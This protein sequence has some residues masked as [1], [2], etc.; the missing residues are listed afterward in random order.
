VA[1]N[2]VARAAAIAAARLACAFALLAARQAAPVSGGEKTRQAAEG[3][4]ELFDGKDLAGW[5]VHSGTARFRVENEVVIGESVAKS[6]NSFLCSDESF[7]DFELTLEYEVDAAL[8]S[9]VQ[10]RSEF[11]PQARTLEID[12]RSIP[13]PAD[14]VHGYQVEIDMDP[15]RNRWWSGGL[16]D[17]ARRGWLDPAG[18]EKGPRGAAFTEQGRRISMPGEWNVLRVVADGAEITT[19]LNGEQRAHVTDRLT[20]RGRIALQVHGVGDDAAHVGMKVRFRHVRLRPLHAAASGASTDDGGESPNTLT[21]AERRDGWRLL[22][23]GA[24]TNGWRS[25]RSDQFPAYGWTIANGILTVQKSAGGESAGGGDIVTRERFSDFELSVDFR[26]TEG[27]NSGIK[28]FVQTDLAPIDGKGAAAT[29]GSAIGCEYQLLDDLRHP[30][31]KLGRD[32]DRTLASLYDLLPAAATKPA[33]AIG[34]WNR[35]RILARGSHVEH[36]LNGVKVLEYE[37]GSEDFRRAVALSKFKGIAGFGEW[38]EGVLL[39]QEHGDEV[40]FRNVK[41]RPRSKP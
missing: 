9:G 34:E 36:W 22:W 2:L 37:R 20:P 1:W 18:D 12:G 35:A 33:R 19:W 7:D 29:T 15:A 8:N 39:L 21:D 30:D 25:A 28:Y 17:E 3:W 16:Y 6:G 10:I 23:D 11:F 13:V 40:S 32:G 14:R 38:K 31:A 4:R 27:A 5:S 41:I 24:T 26:L